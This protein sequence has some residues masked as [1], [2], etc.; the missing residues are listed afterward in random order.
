MK[1]SKI[2]IT[3]A[4]ALFCISHA[5]AQEKMILRGRV[6]DKNDKTSII[7][8]NI[9]E[10]D[11]NERV[12]GG[13]ITN[14]NGDFILEM[15]NP[16]HVIKVSVIGYTA[17]ELEKDPS[18]TII[19]ELET[20]D[21]ALDEV[22]VVAESKSG[23]SLTNI[24]DRDRASSSVK[25][26]LMEMQDVG[27]VSAADALQGKVS[28]LDVISASGDPGSGSQLV[29]RGLSSMGNS[30]PLIVIDGIPQFRIAESFDLSSADTEDISNLINIALQDVKSIE[31]LKDAASTSIYGS[32]GA[33][34]V[35]LI[36]TNKG[37]MGSVQFDYQYKYSLNVQPPAIPMLNGDEYIMLQL[38]AWHNSRGL[39]D[40]PSEIAYDRDDINFYNYTA[41]TDWIGELTRNGETH[42]HYFSVSGGG[43]KTRYF[44]SFSFVDE[45]GTTIGTSSQ[46]FSARTNLDYFLSR[47]LLFQ[48]KFNY[49]TNF[50]E[51]NPELNRRNVREMAYIKS[52]NMSIWEYD[53][54]G[55]L[56]GEYFT[57]INSYQGDGVTFY[58]PVALAKLGKNDTKYSRLENT[59]ML[60]YRIND[61][62]VFRETVSFQFQGTKRNQFYPYNTIGA[63]WLNS[64]VNR[65]REDN[66]MDMALRTETQIAFSS[67]FES[68]KHEISGAFTWITE[69]SE[70]ERMTSQAN[71]IPTT[72]IQDPA[73]QAQI[74]YISTNSGA[75]RA[76]GGLSNINYKY[77]DRYLIQSILR[78][79][80]HSSF[81]RNNRWGLFKGLALGWR[82]SEEPFLSSAEFLEESML[83]FSWGVSGRQPGD[84]YAR[85]ASYE[86]TS[87]GSYIFTPS[88]S[89][90]SIQLD[91][92]RWETITSYN[93]GMELNLFKNNLYVEADFYE[94]VT[95]DILFSNYEI[96]LS[97][98]FDRLRYFN[99]GEM[100]NRGWELMTDIKA[101][102]KKDFLLSFNFNTSRNV[103][104]FNQLPE[105]FN[106]E[107]STSIG[108]GQYPL[109]VT[110]GEPIGSFF[111]FR[112]LGVWPSDEAVVAKDAEGNIL[113]DGHGN[114]IQ[115]TYTDSYIFQGG[116]PVYE[117]VNHDGDIDL[118]DVV[119][120]GDS[121]PDF[122]GGF[123]TNLRYRSFDFAVSFHYR[124][125]FDIINGVAIQTEGMNNRNNQSKAV[126]NRWRVEG[127]NEVGM[128]PRAYMNHPANN[129]GS[130]RYVERGDYLRLNNI[131][132]GYQL[133][134]ELCNRL[135][136]R[137]ANFTLSARK[138]L[139][140]TRYTGQDPEVGQDASDPFWIGVDNAKT[141]PPK[142]V[143]FSIA[144]GF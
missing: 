134:R 47:Q 29:I 125:G 56:T 78:A 69:Q 92:L 84:V 51:G 100:V 59:F 8:A 89:P 88:I 10:Y 1:R 123:G 72:R 95:S 97:S 79:D 102:R 23:S 7:G 128:L 105:N 66:N 127:Q 86:S 37:R 33:D 30:Q 54:Q 115:L 17:Q 3:I 138:L 133:N 20:S 60:Q 81:G 116:D 64:Y 119:Y 120:I 50:T 39:F 139:T 26:D 43:N 19:V 45:G 67:P 114:P 48:V 111:G 4:L 22:T 131:K 132:I 18:K 65:A 61:W 113:L 87:T 24:A 2:L 28:G 25:V 98:G 13:T 53:S 14:I 109:K 77:L 107:R 42:D 124:L 110:E 129:L 75:K 38:E 63:D 83:R 141:P 58:N 31:V 74:N 103:N 16:S 144:I 140:F 27:V 91:N 73:A 101:I 46:R 104:S 62:L 41:N 137:K 57:P 122:I 15:I 70:F 117:D 68:K 36:E 44:N 90:S 130:D 82:F 106:T 94:K 49:V 135:G 32:Q 108:N 121:N 34:G 71:Q 52:P 9:I 6:I 136:I 99:G 96:P 5:E 85:F 40:L 12:V 93:I 55:N 126:L 11:E 76:L 35:L 112:Y 142:I 80:A 21:V 118:N 143:T